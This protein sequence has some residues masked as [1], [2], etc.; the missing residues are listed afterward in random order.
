MDEKQVGAGPV[1]DG[2]VVLHVAGKVAITTVADLTQRARD[3]AVLDLIASMDAR[4]EAAGIP[5]H[6]REAFR[7]AL[8][9]NAT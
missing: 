5:A 3:V 2:M 7:R 8:S 1:P 4:L 9:E 6:W